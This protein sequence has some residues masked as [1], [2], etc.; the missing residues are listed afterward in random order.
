[1]AFISY[2]IF[3]DKHILGRL[4]DVIFLDVVSHRNKRII[5][6]G[7]YDRYVVDLMQFDFCTLG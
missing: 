2:F 5:N 7:V 6:I 4:F 3:D 1:M